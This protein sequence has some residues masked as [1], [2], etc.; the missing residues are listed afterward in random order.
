MKVGIVTQYAYDNMGN[1]L[2]NYA[3]QRKLAEYADSVCTIKNRPKAR[4]IMGAIKQNALAADSMLLHRLCGRY[5]KSEILKFH[6]KYIADSSAYYCTSQNYH[7]LKT[8]DTCELYCAGS[9][10]VW[11]PGSG[12][13][14][15]FHYLGFAPTERTFSYAASFGVDRIPEEY[16]DA[17]RKGLN[18]IKYISVREDAGKRIVEELTGRTDV[19]VLVDPTMLLTT[20]EWDEVVSKPKKKLPEKY[21]L[22]YFLGS[23]SKE[24]R[25]AIQEKAAELGCEIIETMD[26]DSPFYAIGPGEFVWLIKHAALVCTDSFHGSV[27]SFLYGRP[28]AIFDR[29]GSGEDM[30]SRLRTLASKFHLEDC[31][32]NGEKLPQLSPV[33]DYSA[34]YVALEEERAKSKA[35]LDMVFQE[36]ERA[37]LC[38]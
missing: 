6:K 20:Q 25:Q 17:V 38:K 23:I 32:V 33:P 37:G 35:F 26:P 1:K 11:K 16:Q 24:R 9:D 21:L 27:F 31:M 30:S 12:R 5:R 36:A 7:G 3:L 29:K 8:F 18:H 34:G 14:G 10:Q 22:T 19:Q 28:L 4:G 15:V 13:T 2:Q